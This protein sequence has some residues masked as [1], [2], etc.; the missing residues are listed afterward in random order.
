M[1]NKTD[2]IGRS[3]TINYTSSGYV[4]SLV[5]SDGL[6]YHYKYNYNSNNG[7]FYVQVRH[8][9][10]EIE[11]RWYNSEYM[12][13]HKNING[14]TV[15]TV[16]KNQRVYQLTDTKGGITY[17]EYDTKDNL[18]KETYPDGTTI[19]YEYDYRFNKVRRK[20]DQRGIVTDYIHDDNGN[21][22]TMIEAKGTVIERT[23]AYTYDADGNMLTIKVGSNPA[24]VITYDDYGNMLTQTDPEG[25]TTTFTYN[26]LGNMLTRKDAKGNTW[27]YTYD[28]SGIMPIR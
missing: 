27:T 15:K 9:S 5:D 28:D 25:N 7:E 23:T 14:T 10:G 16:V 19:S 26:A 2:P 21:I 18:V 6:G 22:I 13:T 24:T 11:E 3:Y 8:P 4:E 1:T 17:R 20:T 12:L